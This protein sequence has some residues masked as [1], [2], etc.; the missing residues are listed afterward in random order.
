MIKIIKDDDYNSIIDLFLDSMNDTRIGQ[1]VTSDIIARY[2]EVFNK[3]LFSLKNTKSSYKAINDWTAYGILE[4]RRDKEKEWRKFSLVDLIWINLVSQLRV[5]NYPLSKIKTLKGYW[6]EESIILD[7]KRSDGELEYGFYTIKD[8]PYPYLT[9]FLFGV[10]LNM[11]REELEDIYLLI[12]PNK[13]TT[14]YV[15]DKEAEKYEHVDFYSTPLL[16]VYGKE[17]VKK[18]LGMNNYTIILNLNDIFK[19]VLYSENS[20]V[21]EYEEAIK[22]NYLEEFQDYD[23][24]TLKFRNK[25]LHLIEKV[26]IL[27]PKTPMKDL[28][29]EGEF[30]DIEIK[31]QGGKIAYI[32]R[33][34]K[35]RH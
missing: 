6:Y 24:V 8:V 10:M 33:K 30:E 5:A 21:E 7:P 35:E 34:S 11:G 1:L 31:K 22:D 14:G 27:D 15:L 12:S 13:Y 18:A 28:I 16:F 9:Q 25:R 29:N 32:K 3:P 19:E 26:Q 23:E 4:D 17:G 20:I 2:S